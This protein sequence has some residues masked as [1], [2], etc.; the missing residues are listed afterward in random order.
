MT[1]TKTMTEATQQIV[2]AH[3]R[4]G[5]PVEENPMQP[6]IAI[7]DKVRTLQGQNLYNQGNVTRTDNVRPPQRTFRNRNTEG[8]PPEGMP[9]GGPQGGGLPGGKPPRG[10][11]LG[12]GNPD[13]NNCQ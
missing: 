2:K 5:G 11:L 10:G 9:R 13:D 3:I 8:G 7:A 12:G 4:G 6:S 1:T